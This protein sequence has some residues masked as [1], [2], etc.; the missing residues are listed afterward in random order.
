MAGALVPI[1]EADRVRK[2]VVTGCQFVAP[3][4]DFA[5]PTAVAVRESGCGTYGECQEV[6][7]D[8]VSR[9]VSG[10]RWSVGLLVGSMLCLGHYR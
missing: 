7:V 3:Q 4:I 8:G 2:I 1:G 5:H 10:R 6:R 9:M